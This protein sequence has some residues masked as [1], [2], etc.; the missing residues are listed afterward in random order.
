MCSCKKLELF[1][2]VRGCQKDEILH[3]RLVRAPQERSVHC[4]VSANDRMIS[5][6]TASMASSY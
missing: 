4:I 2:E 5:T 6:N 1:V 3:G